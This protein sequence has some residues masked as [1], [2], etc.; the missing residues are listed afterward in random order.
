MTKKIDLVF[1]HLGH[2]EIKEFQVFIKKYWK[3][4]HLYSRDQFV[5]DWQHKGQNYY[6]CLTAKKMT[7]IIGVQCFIPLWHFDEHLEKTD[8]LFALFRAIDG[9]GIGA[10]LQLFRKVL[11]IYSPTFVGSVDIEKHMIS[12]HKWNGFLVDKMDHH[13]LLSPYRA[14]YRIAIVQKAVAE[15]PK[16]SS[17]K[18]SL[19]EMSVKD[20]KN[21]NRALYSYQIPKKSPK[22]VMARY[23]DHP[24]YSYKVIGVIKDGELRALIVIRPVYVGSAVAFRIVDFIGPNE[25]II[26]FSLEAHKLLKQYEGEY[27]DFYS[28][29]IP[30]QLLKTAGLINRRET[31]GLVIPNHFEPFQQ[32][33]QDLLVAVKTSGKLSKVR[34]FK[35]DGDS[36]RPSRLLTDRNT[37]E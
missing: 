35:G 26:N 22:Y 5:F 24:V 29:G 36:D 27:L 8:I 18:I 21:S 28:Y 11:E 25:Q 6:H 14:N 9:E 20:L 31:Q 12:Y 1:N 34:L 7:R 15:K 32:E 19:R 33:N 4:N 30:K 16:G 17:E 2:H 13:V 10:G 3:K 37:S 23:F